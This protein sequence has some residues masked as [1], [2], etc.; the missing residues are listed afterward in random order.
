M[1]RFRNALPLPALLLLSAEACSGDAADGATTIDDTGDAQA[2][3]ASADGAAPRRA[4]PLPSRGATVALSP[5]DA[6]LDGD[7]AIP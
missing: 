3:D 6:R 1:I 7:A 2:A 5:D 4:S